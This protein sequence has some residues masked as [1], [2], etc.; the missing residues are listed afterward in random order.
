MRNGKQILH[1]D[2]TRQEENLCRVDHASSADRKYLWHNNFAD[3]RSVY[4]S[5]ITFMLHFDV[6]L[7]NFYGL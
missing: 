1:D 7:A 4:V 2:E 5:Y 6:I 3:A